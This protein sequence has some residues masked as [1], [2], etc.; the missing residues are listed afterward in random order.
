MRNDRNIMAGKVTRRWRQ[1]PNFIEYAN[2]RMTFHHKTEETAENAWRLACRPIQSFQ[3]SYTYIGSQTRLSYFKKPISPPTSFF[4]NDTWRPD[5]VWEVLATHQGKFNV[6]LDG[7]IRGHVE[8]VH[9]Q[10]LEE[11]SGHLQ[12][13]PMWQNL[14]RGLPLDLLPGGQHY[15]EGVAALDPLDGLYRELQEFL[16]LGGEGR[17]RKCPG[18]QRYFVQSSAHSQTFCVRKCRRN[19]NPRRREAN[20]KYQR[21]YREKQREKRIQ[22]ELKKV[23][24]AKARL[25]VPGKEDLTLDEVLEEAKISRRRWAFLRRYEKTHYRMARDTDL[26]RA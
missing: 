13:Y 12:I 17:L 9:V 5:N 20:A 15:Y 19:S 14:P 2:D 8:A 16:R 23:H 24:E 4:F 21:R 3:R 22:E 26:T 6:L 1:F 7:I 25:R 18:C 11:H 10:W